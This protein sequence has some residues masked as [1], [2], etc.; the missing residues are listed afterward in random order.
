VTTAT[1]ERTGTLEHRRTRARMHV[2]GISINTVAVLTIALGAWGAIVP[3]VGPLF[4]Y[5]A[6]GG[7]AWHW[8]LAH[9]L[10]GLAP[11]ALAVVVGFLLFAETRGIKVGRGLPGLFAA[12]LLVLASGAWF[13]VGP[14][15][16]PVISA[17]GSYFE[18]ASPYRGL[19]NLLGYSFG[20]GILL[21]AAGAFIMGWA[22]R[23]GAKEL[24][25]TKEARY[26][27]EYL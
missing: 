21:T 25:P 24:P 4:G 23:H 7:G 18:A 22:A 6:T 2:G 12:G 26:S 14:A 19:L 15:A 5:G 27:P 3:Y 10:L 1:I 8:N 11:G 13:I 20:T 9:S 16:W 17:H